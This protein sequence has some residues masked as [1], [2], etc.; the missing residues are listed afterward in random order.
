MYFWVDKVLNVFVFGKPNS[1][2]LYPGL[3]GGIKIY[4]L[5]ASYVTDIK[6]PRLSTLNKGKVLGGSNFKGCQLA[7][8]GGSGGW[9]CLLRDKG[10]EDKIAILQFP[11]REY[12]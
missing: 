5:K 12:P 11:S 7:Y 3:F 9:S 10:R 1:V 8:Y 6:F 2:P 4:F